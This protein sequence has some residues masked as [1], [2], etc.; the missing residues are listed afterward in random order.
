MPEKA[1]RETLNPPHACLSKIRS[2]S[3]NLLPP[4]PIPPLQSL[5]SLLLSRMKGR[6]GEVVLWHCYTFKTCRLKHCTCR[7]FDVV[8]P[9]VISSSIALYLE[10]Y[11][12]LPQWYLKVTKILK[13]AGCRPVP[14][15]R[16]QSLTGSYNAARFP[17]AQELLLVAVY[18]VTHHNPKSFFQFCLL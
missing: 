3:S 11:L 5:V 2:L 13:H 17:V 4:V 7:F 10:P 12:L 15:L 16:A 9:S 8:T 6:S 1:L 14:S 18:Y